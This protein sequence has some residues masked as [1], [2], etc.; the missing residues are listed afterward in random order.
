VIN[1]REFVAGAGAVLAGSL[2]GEPARLLALDNE[3]AQIS[4]DLGSKT[5]S[6]PHFWEKAAGSDRTVVGLRE[7]WRQDLVR[8]RRETGIQSDRCHGLFDDEMGIASQG[9][10]K[11]NFLY[12][13]Q[14]YDFMLDQGVRPFV[15]LSF[16]RRRSPVPATASSPI[17][18]M[19]RL[20]RTG[21]T[22]TTW[23]GRSPTT[24]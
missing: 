1:R 17:K 2:A 24:V 5:S 23:F 4:I 21:R 14:I 9:A 11:F 3:A 15:E 10:G 19:S 6:L 7:Q 18:A 12:V 20:A 16:M 22:G 13:D 8:C